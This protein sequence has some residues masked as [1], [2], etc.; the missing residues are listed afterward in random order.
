MRP[1]RARVLHSDSIPCGL[2][3][4]AP[5]H[6]Q[7]S[8][9]LRKKKN[10]RGRS[11]LACSV[12]HRLLVRKRSVF[13]F[14]SPNFLFSEPDICR[15]HHVEH[16]ACAPRNRRSCDCPRG[17]TCLFPF[18]TQRDRKELNITLLSLSGITKI[19]ILAASFPPSQARSTAFATFG[20][21]API[22]KGVSRRAAYSELVV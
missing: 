2:G 5:S 4:P 14:S 17:C 15:Q 3:M 18:P 21:G 8:R 1:S 12:R 19:G 6:R 11:N 22:G 9:P 13:V 7:T 16:L 20:A 10:V